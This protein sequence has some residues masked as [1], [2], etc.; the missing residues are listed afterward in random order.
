ME[1]KIMKSIMDDN[2]SRSDE[3][4]RILKEKNIFMINFIGSPG[5]GKTSLLEK[6]LEQLA[7]K[8]KI[9]V[10]EGDVATNR[11]AERLKKFNI[12][13]ILINTDG[14]CYLPS[15]SIEN[16]LKELDLK[17]V[18]L[19]LIEN[20]GNLLCPSHF[21]IGENMK[22]AVVSTTEGDDKPAKYPLLFREAKA[23]ILNKTDLLEFTNFNKNNFINDLKKI[24]G[25]LELF[26][27]SCTK[28]KGINEL[29][30]WLEKTIVGHQ[31]EVSL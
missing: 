8:Y 16:S 5:A 29:I 19:I 1:Y 30:G 4:R 12:Q 26:E 28:E 9:A 24:N 20:V 14:G 6:I 18:N 10:I 27:I 22:V 31:S 13:M 15:I 23:C 11:D 7:H 2:Q 25:N 3:I 17:N 21:D